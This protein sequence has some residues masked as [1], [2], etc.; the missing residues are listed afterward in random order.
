MSKVPAVSIIMPVYNSEK[1]LEKS[2]GSVLSQTLKDIEI[3]CVDDCSSDDSFRVLKEFAR[4]DK[5]IRVFKNK[6]NIGPGGSRNFG[7]K[8]ARGEYVCFLDSDDWLERDACEK[9]Y[10][11]G[12]L[13]DLDVVYIWPKLVFA[14]KIILD[15]RLLSLKDIEDNGVVF[16][17]NLMR[18]VAWAP[19][20]KFIKRDLLIKNKIVFPDIYIA[21]DMNFSAKVIY[22]AKRI[23]FV[24]EYLY[25]YNLREGSLMSYTKPKRRIENYFE[26]VRLMEKFLGEREILGKYQRELFHFNLYNYLA[27][28]GVMFYADGGLDKMLYKKKIWNDKNFKIMNILRVG[29]FDSVMAG[30]FLIKMGLFNPVFRIREFFRV[31]FGKWGKRNS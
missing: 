6:K 28:Y 5:R 7:V 30:S 25:N 17:K 3:I 23:G 12:R 10:K 22:Y 29:I 18:K 27:I 1:Y 19:W 2:I 20:S 8:K 15:K 9:L 11:K 4:K 26:S 21:E 31:L 24:D 13:D 16:R 14:D